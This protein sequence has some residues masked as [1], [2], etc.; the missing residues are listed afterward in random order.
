[1]ATEAQQTTTCPHCAK[2][3]SPGASTCPSCG[4]NLSKA[5]CYLIATIGVF[6]SATIGVVWIP[7][8][9]GVPI[10]LAYAAYARNAF[11]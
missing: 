9:I 6:F 2:T 11:N 5:V 3:V 1:M 7:A 10:S 4:G 8:L